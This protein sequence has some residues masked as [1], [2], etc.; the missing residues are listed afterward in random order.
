MIGVCVLFLFVESWWA[1][2]CSQVWLCEF[3]DTLVRSRLQGE[4]RSASVVLWFIILLGAIQLDPSSNL[5]A[6]GAIAIISMLRG[7]QLAEE[8]DPEGVNTSAST[9]TID[10]SA[11]LPA[12]E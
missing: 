12:W 7:D 10:P 4:R 11:P 5:G 8:T 9:D 2:Y 3:S 1:V 6:I